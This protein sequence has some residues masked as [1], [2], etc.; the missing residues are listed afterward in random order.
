[1]KAN[2]LR[3]L[4]VMLAIALAEAC[5]GRLETVDITIDAK[6]P[7]I[8]TLQMEWHRP[9]GIQCGKFGPIC[10]CIYNLGDTFFYANRT[11]SAVPTLDFVNYDYVPTYEWN[12]NV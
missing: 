1:M 6:N 3:F 12:G 9:T 4:P 8:K 2:V 7:T 11:V 10:Q 5:T